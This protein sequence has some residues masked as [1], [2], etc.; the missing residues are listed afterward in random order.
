LQPAITTTTT[1]TA[2]DN[3]APPTSAIPTESPRKGVV[4]QPAATTTTT[5]STAADNDAPSTSVTPTKSPIIA[6]D[7]NPQQQ[8]GQYHPDMES[9]DSTTK[10]CTNGLNEDLRSQYF[11]E[12]G[13]D[14]C[15]DYWGENSCD[16]VDLCDVQSGDTDGDVDDVDANENNGSE[17]G[18]EGATCGKWHPESDKQKSWLVHFSLLSLKSS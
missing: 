16:I 18:D 7:T 2:A 11:Y 5:S 12:T 8:C 9:Q 3:D 15:R 10:R 4:M 14:C 13:D 6:N 17:E 1:S